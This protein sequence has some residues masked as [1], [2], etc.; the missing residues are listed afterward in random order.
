LKEL[1]MPHLEKLGQSRL[2]E[3][4]KA[5]VDILQANLNSI[6]SSFSNNLSLAYLKLTQ[7]EIQIADFVKRGKTTKNI[8]EL[9]NLSRK[10]VESHRKN[11]RV[12]LGLLNTKENLRTH[13][14]LIK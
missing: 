5:Y 2:D 4:Q 13:L 12:K 6:I 9:L 1:I 3:K 8:A 7:A 11:I 10:T 14:S